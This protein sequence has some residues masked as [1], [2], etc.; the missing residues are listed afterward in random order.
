M[1]SLSYVIIGEAAS[2]SNSSRIVFLGRRPRIIKSH[3]A[4]GFVAKVK[5]Q[6]KPAKKLLEGDLAVEIHMW[7]KSRRPDLDESLVLD[8]LQGIAYKNDR[9]IKEKHVYHHL[10][11]LKPRVH[12]TVSVIP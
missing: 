4:L 1:Q 10:D 3:K 5:K 7:Y 11:K 8:C 9:Q 12:I 2:K 6:L